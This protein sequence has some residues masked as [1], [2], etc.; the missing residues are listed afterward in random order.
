MRGYL[1][2][3]CFN[4]CFRAKSLMIYARRVLGNTLLVCVS[5]LDYSGNQT[6]VECS[7]TTSPRA[8]IRSAVYIRFFWPCGYTYFTK[9]PI[10]DSRDYTCQHQ[11][12]LA[13][14]LGVYK[15]QAISEPSTNCEAMDVDICLMLTSRH[16]RSSAN[17]DKTSRQRRR[18]RNIIVSY[19]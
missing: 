13:C 18:K 17:T 14:V 11:K 19:A 16:M 12:H 3:F 4:V 8:Q 7:Y 10:S 15:L 5:S 2:K 9:W 6:D 1:H